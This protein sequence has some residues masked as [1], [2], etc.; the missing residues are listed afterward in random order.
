[1]RIGAIAS[2]LVLVTILVLAVPCAA[3]EKVV[4]EDISVS[5]TTVSLRGGGVLEITADGD[6]NQFLLVSTIFIRWS[7]EG[8][9]IPISARRFSEELRGHLAQGLRIAINEDEGGTHVHVY[10]A[11][12]RPV[13][14]T[15]TIRRDS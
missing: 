2:S 9:A 11:A 1:M 12:Q 4:V 5:D 3:Q 7:E 14:A 13:L 15:Y 8:D 10:I 6:F